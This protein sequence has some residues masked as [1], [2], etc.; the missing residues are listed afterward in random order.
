MVLKIIIKGAFN[1]YG[2]ANIHIAVNN[3]INNNLT[4]NCSG[5]QVERAE[6]SCGLSDIY[7]N[8]E[9]NKANEINRIRLFHTEPCRMIDSEEICP[10]KE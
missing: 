4:M 5:S 8:W 10:D 1:Y 2:G 7:R 3:L 6:E 9:F